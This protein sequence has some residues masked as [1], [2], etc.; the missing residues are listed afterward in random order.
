V[1]RIVPLRTLGHLPGIILDAIDTT[2]RGCGYLSRPDDGGG[3]LD[4]REIG[5]GGLFMAGC[6]ATEVFEFAEEA[7]DTTTLLIDVAVMT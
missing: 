7:L 4:Y 6:D 3:G 1:E 2:A 5:S